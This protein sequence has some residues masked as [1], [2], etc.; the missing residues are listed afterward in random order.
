GAER[1]AAGAAV[2]L[3]RH[4]GD[5]L[6]EMR[7]VDLV[8]DLLPVIDRRRRVDGREGRIARR[9]VEIVCVGAGMIA[10]VASASHENAGSKAHDRIVAGSA[11]H[12]ALRHELALAV[13]PSIAMPGP[14]W[15]TRLTA[16]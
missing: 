11:R 13:A 4:V 7:R 1:H 2:A 12:A 16:S 8:E 9:G 6:L 15:R 3:V 14:H 10:G 5:E